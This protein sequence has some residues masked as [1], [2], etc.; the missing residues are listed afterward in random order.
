MYS[1]KALGLSPAS[2]IDVDILE[3][4]KPGVNPGAVKLFLY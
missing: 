1:E 3:K 2:E 4:M